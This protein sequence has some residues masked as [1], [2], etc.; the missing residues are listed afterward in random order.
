MPEMRGRIKK[1]NEKLD[2]SNFERHVPISKYTDYTGKTYTFSP[3]LNLK[4]PPRTFN[5]LNSR[6]VKRMVA[7]MAN[8]LP[9]DNARILDMGSGTGFLSLMISKMMKDES[10]YPRL[11]LM[12]DQMPS[13]VQASLDNIIENFFTIF[14]NNAPDIN[15]IRS[16]LFTSDFFTEIGKREKFDLILFNAP[17]GH[18]EAKY[19]MEDDAA[20]WGTVWDPTASPGDNI[21]KRFLENAAD[22]LVEHGRIL[23]MT[24]E[25]NDYDPLEGVKF[26]SRSKGGC[27]LVIDNKAY[28]EWDEYGTTKVLVLSPD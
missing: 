22:Y 9:Y 19:V 28:P 10:R 24:A 7:A 26:E 23:M 18:P 20:E 14:E 8:F 11:L 27:G 4:I 3:D 12:V 13:A 16:D 1:I 6:S 5:P 25:Y 2:I 21:K 17:T 15:A